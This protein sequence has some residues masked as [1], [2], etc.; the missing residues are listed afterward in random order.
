MNSKPI[1]FATHASRAFNDHLGSVLEEISDDVQAACGDNLIALIL[2]GGYGRGEGGVITIKGEEKP[3]NDIDFSIIVK[4]IGSYPVDKI[5]AVSE[6]YEKVI[7]IDVDFS[8]PLTLKAVKNWPHW[9]MWHDLLN[10]HIV[11]RGSP[12]VLTDCAPEH[13]KEPLPL[14]EAIRLLLNRGT[15]LLWA[16]RVISENEPAPDKDFIRRNYYKCLLALGDALLVAEGVYTTQYAGR[17]QILEKR[18]AL[19][20]H[21]SFQTIMP[22]YREALEFKFRPDSFDSSEIPST[23]LQQAAQLWAEVFLYVEAKRLKRPWSSMDAYIQWKGIR[24]KEQH[25]GIKLARNFLQ[26]IKIGLIS[27]KYRREFLYRELPPLLD[28]TEK[29]VAHWEDESKQFLKTWIKFN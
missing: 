10:G 16:R 14:T 3:Y 23:K 18:D 9:M 11:L 12:S 1:Q 28:L 2:G 4:D 21:L 13:I 26:N 17:D 29:K 5:K 19:D 24:E 15:G 25:C 7:E 22:L 6:K 20:Q 27:T 8:R